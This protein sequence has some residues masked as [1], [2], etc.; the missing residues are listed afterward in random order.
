MLKLQTGCV[1]DRKKSCKKQIEIWKCYRFLRCHLQ[2]FWNLL[3]NIM[4]LKLWLIKREEPQIWV[5]LRNSQ[6]LSFQMRANKRKT[7]VRSLFCRIPRIT[8][9]KQS[10]R[11]LFRQ[12]HPL[13]RIR[14]KEEA[15]IERDKE[16]IVKVQKD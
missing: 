4:V 10:I 2:T 3:N 14:M 8:I 16:A 5:I 13:E 11:A 1:L 12:I 7:K 6:C 15:R 9:F